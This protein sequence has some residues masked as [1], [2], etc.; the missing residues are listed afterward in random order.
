MDEI[1]I[2]ATATIIVALIGLFGNW[3]LINDNRKRELSIKQLEIEKQESNLILESLKEFWEYQNKVYQDVLRVASILT[4]NK[5]IDSEE[6][7]KAYIRLWELKY[8]ELPTCDSE[9]IELA[10]EVFSDLAYEKKRLKVE[11]IKSIKEYEKLMKP[12]LKDISKS[13]RNSSILLD[14]TKIMRLRIKENMNGQKEL[15]RN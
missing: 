9:E 3:Y 11:D 13:I 2:A 12:C 15:K 5:E 1:T 4:F 6:F 10:L 7:Q 14:Y 8:G